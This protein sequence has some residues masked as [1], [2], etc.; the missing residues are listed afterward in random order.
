MKPVFHHRPV[1]GPFED[2]SVYVRVL[3]EKKGLLFDAGDV[4]GLSARE[5]MKITDVFITHTHIDHFIGFDTIIRILLKRAA[6]VTFYGPE[7]IIKCITGKLDGYTWNL[8][9]EYPLVVNAVEIRRD[10]ILKASFRAGE[11]FTCVDTGFID[12]TPTVLDTPLFYV[13]AVILEHDVPS[14]GF[15]IKEKKHINIDKAR[16]TGRGFSVGP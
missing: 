15:Y 6:P 5:L 3:H 14:L 2:P 16:L 10:I 7:G 11:E 12:Y 9:T 8:I 13:N 1:N 4:P